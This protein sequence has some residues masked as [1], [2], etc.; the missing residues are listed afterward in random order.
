MRSVWSGVLGTVLSLGGCWGDSSIALSLQLPSAAVAAEF[1]TSCVRA[2]EVYLNGGNYPADTVDYFRDCVD[3]EE[4]GATFAEVRAQIAGRLET[5]LPASGLS[6]I[7]VYGYAGSCDAPGFRREFD[8]LFFGTSP[9][10]GGDELSV[11]VIP[12][13]SCAVDNVTIRPIDVL[14]LVRGG[15]AAAAWPEGKLVVSTLSPVPFFDSTQWWGSTGATIAGGVASFRG[16]TKV[17]PRSCLAVGLYEELD[18]WT[19]VTCVPPADQRSCATG[20]ELEAPVIDIGVWVASAETSKLNEYGS[21]VIGAVYNGT[22]VAGAQVT[23]ADAD[24][25]KAAI[26]YFDMPVGVE[27]GTGGLLPTD[28]TATGPSGLF[29]V[30]TSSMVSVTISA[31]G[32]SVTRKIAG[33]TEAASAVVIKL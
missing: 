22:P 32:R 13:L 8:L 17:G 33:N 20:A 31:S 19:N 30:Y 24:R 11:A 23:L 7:E 2:V 14:K 6:G 10:I 18:G 3:V 15:C 27:N 28:A 5:K 9:Y 29:G 21:L 4:P 26:V 16:S 25:D 1:D 12:N